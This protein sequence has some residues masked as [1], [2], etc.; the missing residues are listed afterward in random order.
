MMAGKSVT[1]EHILKATKIFVLMLVTLTIP[2]MVSAQ[3]GDE[4]VEFEKNA[5]ELFLGGT[6]AGDDG[7]SFS[8]GLAYE[9]RL[10]EKVGIGGLI[11]YTE[12]REWVLA[13]PVYFH[14]TEPWKFFLAP[15]LEH[16]DGENEFMVRVGGSYE[17][18]MGSW[19]LAPEL[20]FDF[21]DGDVKTIFGLNIGIGF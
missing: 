12:G 4:T 16:E 2:G 15:G 20:S 13:I 14:P 21:V 18:E 10:K 5:M 17:F 1:G 6:Y 7:T 9:R 11:E 3:D 19:T 8:T